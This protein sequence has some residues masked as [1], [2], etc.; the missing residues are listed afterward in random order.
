MKLPLPHIVAAA[1]VGSLVWIGTVRETY[2][3]NIAFHCSHEVANEDR[4]PADILIVGN[5]QTGAAIDPLYVEELI[6][7]ARGVRVEKLAIVQANI[8]GMRMMV[9]EYLEKRGAPKL[10]VYQ[11]MV[12]VADAWQTPAGHPIHPRANL[13][14]QDWDKLVKLQK[15]AV[16]SPTDSWLPHWAER[17]YRTIPAMWID[18]Q[19]ERMIATLSIPRL[20]G[21]KASC[22][23]EY[24]YKLAIIWPYGQMEPIPGDPRYEPVD[25]ASLSDWENNVSSRKPTDI[26]NP[27]RMFEIDQN[28]KLIAEMKAAGSEVM[29]VG[30][31]SKGR[32]D[33]DVS[34][35]ADYGKVFGSEVTD[36]RGLLS[37][38]EQQ[39]LE[40]LFRDPIHLNFGGAEIIS[41]HMAEELKGRVE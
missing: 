16:S 6:D 28:R 3:L 13:A 4:P 20:S 32:K 9:Q 12:V 35:F 7:P 18:R 31:P 33:Q 25:D 21:T 36:I 10:I 29:L 26:F 23:S 39:K 5:S 41:R 22:R 19:V 2:D 24:K 38:E 8:A 37:P 14:Y 34:D 15:D 40:T 27:S 30:Y 11:P 17:G 1:V